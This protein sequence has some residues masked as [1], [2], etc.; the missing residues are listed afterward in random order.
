MPRS[1][2]PRDSRGERSPVHKVSTTER[3]RE[4]S[5]RDKDREPARGRDAERERSDK[6]KERARSRDVDKDKDREGKRRRED[7]RER[8]RDAKRSRRTRSR[9]RERAREKSRDPARRPA[10]ERENGREDRGRDDRGRSRDHDRERG[11]NDRGRSKD[12][13]SG[14]TRD[15]DRERGRDDR[16]R[17]RDRGGSRRPEE[18]GHIGDGDAAKQNGSSAPE[19]GEVLPAPPAPVKKAEVCSD[20]MFHYVGGCR[21]NSERCML[22][23]PQAGRIRSASAIF[24]SAQPLSLEELLKKR[25]A[26]KQAQSK[27]TF[28]SK[29][30]RE[31]LALK[32]REVSFSFSF[33]PLRYHSLASDTLDCCVPQ[34]PCRRNSTFCH[35]FSGSICQSCLCFHFTRRRWQ[36]QPQQRCRTR[37][38]RSSRRRRTG[39]GRRNVAAMTTGGAVTRCVFTWAAVV[40]FQQSFGTKSGGIG[41][42][43]AS[44]PCAWRHLFCSHA[45]QAGPAWRLCPIWHQELTSCSLLCLHSEPG[46][47]KGAGDDQGS[48]PGRREEEKEGKSHAHCT[49]CLPFVCRH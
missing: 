3:D 6:D 2:S 39:G 49:A 38:A 1:A 43:R 17:S 34:Q 12:R 44:W 14:R 26:E 33:F 18:N 29:K 46:A 47:G 15:R 40:S 37:T 25:E 13:D 9:S 11:R 10:D 31:E 20:F 30:Q 5:D 22:F 35:H 19:P 24:V 16:G 7:S 8:E 4:R 23:S 45:R 27:P 28:L 48:I 42:S 41:H 36:R 21:W 32:R